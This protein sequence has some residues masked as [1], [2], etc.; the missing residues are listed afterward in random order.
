MPFRPR[1]A[2]SVSI[3]GPCQFAWS[4]FETARFA[5][6][7]RDLADDLAAAGFEAGVAERGLKLSGWRSNLQTRWGN[8]RIITFHAVPLYASHMTCLIEGGRRVEQVEAT[9]FSHGRKP[10]IRFYVQYVANPLKSILVQV[11]H[12]ARLDMIEIEIFESDVYFK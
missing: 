1:S 11:F 9:S 4:R 12:M 8:R 6:F 7:G 10:L 3:P 2:T 5:T